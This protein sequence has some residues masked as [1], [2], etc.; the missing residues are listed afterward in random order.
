MQQS[1]ASQKITVTILGSVAA[2]MDLARSAFE[3]LTGLNVT[4]DATLADELDI[5]V[6]SGRASL[7]LDQSPFEA[8]VKLIVGAAT[9][10]VGDKLCPLLPLPLAEVVQLHP[11]S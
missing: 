5:D 4:A 10:K 7:G 8:V 3:A 11:A 9:T 6:P 1:V 2:Q